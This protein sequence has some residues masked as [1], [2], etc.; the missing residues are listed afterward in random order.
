MLIGFPMVDT[1]VTLFDGAYHE[2]RGA[3]LGMNARDHVAW[4]E[5][6]ASRHS[7][8]AFRGRQRAARMKHATRRG[9]EWAWQLAFD[10]RARTGALN[11]G[12]G[13]WG[14]RQ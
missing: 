10:D 13:D 3:V 9:V 2:A 4:R 11:D 6:P 7:L 8:F 12:I 1:K 5:L 14:G